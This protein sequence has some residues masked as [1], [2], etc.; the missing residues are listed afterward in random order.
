[1]LSLVYRSV[2]DN[3]F[4]LPEIYSMLSRAKD[5]NSEHGITGCL[6]YHNSNFLQLLEGEEKEVQRLFEKIS[7]D[8]RH[9]DIEIIKEESHKKPLFDCWSMAFHDYG[10]NAMS[11]HL[12][13]QQID[14][15]VNDSDVFTVKSDLA[16]PFFSNAKEILFSN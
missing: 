5:Y 1:M 2:A 3:S 8:D 6:L 13:M 10:Q 9:H 4:I 7:N 15:F 11:A 14:S 16:L 12:K